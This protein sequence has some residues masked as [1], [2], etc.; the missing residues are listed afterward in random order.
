MHVATGVGAA[1]LTAMAVIAWVST[2]RG[3]VGES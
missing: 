2:G 1:V 3:R